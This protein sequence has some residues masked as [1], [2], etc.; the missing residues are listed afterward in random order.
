L[1]WGLIASLYIGNAMLLILNLPLVGLWVKLLAIPRPALYAGI[2]VFAALGAYGLRQSWFDLALLY[3]IG[4]AGF[5]MR[6][7]G[8]PVAPVIVG[9]IL[10]PLS[11]QQFRRA[12]AI[13]QGDLSVFVTHPIAAALLGLVLAVVAAPRAAGVLR[14]SG[15]LTPP[16][17]ADRLGR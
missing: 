3:L 13:S 5:V 14:R 10:G 6:L 12:L 17:A 11:E 15:R 7:Y 9:L 4:L 1:V 2:L 16:A 8:F